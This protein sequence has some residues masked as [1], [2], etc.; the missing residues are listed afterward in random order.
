MFNNNLNLAFHHYEKQMS[1][2]EREIIN[3]FAS[4]MEMPRIKAPKIRKLIIAYLYMTQDPDKLGTIVNHKNC[5]I[6]SQSDIT[7]LI[8]SFNEYKD[9]L[10]APK[11]TYN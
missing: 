1:D 9:S 10:E 6:F 8:T 4:K 7:Q 5:R 3:T 2:K 11:K